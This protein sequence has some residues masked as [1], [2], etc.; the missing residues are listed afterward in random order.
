MRAKGGESSPVAISLGDAWGISKIRLPEQSVL[1]FGAVFHWAE[2][3][4][5]NDIFFRLL[6]PTLHQLVLKQKKMSENSA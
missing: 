5:R 4:V 1:V 6:T 2:F 3:S